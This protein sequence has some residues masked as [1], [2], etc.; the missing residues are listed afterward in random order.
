[1]RRLP[2]FVKLIFA[3]V[4]TLGMYTGITYGGRDGPPRIME[5]P[6]S[7]RNVYG[8][9]VEFSI[10][11][12]GRN[13]KYQ[14]QYKPRIKGGTWT[15]STDS[16][17][18][19]NKLKLVANDQNEYLYRCLV[20]DDTYS[21]DKA[22]MS[23]AASLYVLD[24]QIFEIKYVNET[25]TAP[26]IT[27]QPLS[28]MLSVGE[29]ATFTVEATGTD[30]TYQWQYK[31]SLPNSAWT[32]LTRNDG[33]GFD[34]NTFTTA[35]LTGTQDHYQYRCLVRSTNY[36][37][38]DEN[39]K[40]SDSATLQVTSKGYVDIQYINEEYE[41]VE[42]P[43]SQS[44]YAGTTVKFRV[45]TTGSTNLTY[46]WLYKAPGTNTSWTEVP[47]SMGNGAKTAELTISPVKEEYENYQ[48][49]CSVGGEYY[50]YE[51]AKLSS[52]ATLLLL[53]ETQIADVQYDNSKLMI[54][55]WTIPADNTVIKLPVQGTGLNITVDWGDGTATET[56]TTQ[57]PSH[58]Y[59]T[60]G[61]Y[62]IAV[63][64]ECPEWGYSSYSLP[65][66]TSNYYTYTQ[67]LT[68]VKQFGEL[69][70]T[71]YGFT[72]CEK[73]TEVSGDNLVTDKTFEK[74]TSMA[75]MFN[76]CSG[77]TTLDAS[78]FNTSNVTNMSWMFQYCKNLISLDL[79]NFDTSKVTDMSYMFSYCNSLTSLNI[80]N[81]N[82]SNV[83]GMTW[84]FY[85]CR[86][87]TSLDLSSFNTSKVT[88]MLYMFSNCSSTTSLD[89]S[90]FDTS[91]VTNMK[92]MFSNC[93]S[94]TSLDV[95]S[96]NTSNTQ[97]MIS[98]FSN[99]QS[100]TSLDVSN[101]DTSS[102]D[103]MESM[104][105]GCT[106]L[107]SILL[108]EKFTVYSGTTNMFSNCSKL[109]AVITTS[110]T[111]VANQ[112]KGLLPETA[113]LYVPN[114]AEDTYKAT[115]SG[116]TSLSQIKP[117]IEPVGKTNMTLKLG[118]EYTEQG[119]TVA[120][121]TEADSKYY[122]CYG[123]TL[124]Q[125]G[126][127]DTSK[128]GTYKVKYTLTK[129]GTETSSEVRNVDVVDKSK[130][131]ITEWNVSGDAG[132]TVTLPVS[133]TGL[134]I[135]VDWG[136]GSAIETITTEYPTHTYAQTGVYEISVLGNCPEWGYS[137]Y[138][139]PGDE[140]NTHM[141]YLTKI[142]QFGELNA[143][144]YGF[145][146]CG[147]L[148]EV[149]GENLATENTFK[150][151]TSMDNMFIGC[152]N[153][154]FTELKLNCFKT[155]TVTS[156]RNM[157]NN[158]VNLVTLDLNGFDTSNVTNMMAMFSCCKKLKNLDISTFNTSNVENMNSMFGSCEEMTSIDVSNLDT[159][160]AKNM[161]GMFQRCLKLESI[162]LSSFNTQNVE[163]LGWMFAGCT[164][165]E[166]LDLS[167]FNTSK[168]TNMMAMF[169][170]GGMKSINLSSFDTSKVTTMEEMF[171]YSKIE[172]IDVSNFNTSN[173][174]NMR[175][176][177]GSCQ[178]TALD[179]RNF[180]TSKVTDMHGMFSW[181]KI[182]TLDISNFDT[183]NVYRETNANVETSTGI[184][185]LTRGASRLKS[186][187]IGDKFIIPEGAN[188][189]VFHNKTSAIITTSPTP[190]ANQFKGLIPETTTLYVQNGS[191]DAYR[192]TL[193]G[194]TSSSKIKPIIEPIGESS[195][196][197]VQ[198]SEY[199]DEGCTVAGF[200]GVDSIYYTCYGYGVSSTSDVDT[201]TTGNYKVRYSLTKDGT[202][203]SNAERD[204][205]VLEM[206]NVPT[207]FKAS[208]ATS[209][210]KINLTWETN[211]MAETT[212]CKLEYLDDTGAWKK[213]SD[214]ATSPYI[215]SG[216]SSNKAYEYRI[217]AVTKDDVQSKFAYAIGRTAY[218]ELE[219]IIRNDKIAPII[220][221]IE[222]TP[223]AEYI[224]SNNTI[225][226]KF[227]AED[228]NY[229][230]EES[231]IKAE[232][233]VIKVGGIVNSD[234]TKKITKLKTTNGEEYELELSNVT[235][236]GKL[237]L[238]IPKDKIVDKAGNKNIETTLDIPTFVANG[239]ISDSK[240]TVTVDENE[241]TIINNQ[242]SIAEIVKIEYQYR[243][244][245]DTEFTT[246]PNGAS[247]D[248]ATSN[249][250]KDAL[251]DTYYEI[252]TVVEDS[253]GNKKESKTVTVKTSSLD[254][255]LI[256][257][258]INPTTLTSGD[259]TATIT[260]NSKFHKEYS[261]DGTNYISLTNGNTKELIIKANLTIYARLTDGKNY[262]D[263]VTYEV[264]NID[265]ERP[266]IGKVEVS[267]SGKSNSKQII[268]TDVKD[269]GVSGIKGYYI[270]KTADLDNP[271]WVSFEGTS[272]AYTIKENGTYYVWVSDNVGN[273]SEAEI[274][275]ATGIVSG[276]GN[277]TYNEEM[278]IS[279]GETAKIEITYTG[280]A[281]SE[282][283][284]S[285][286]SSIVKV[287]K[288][289]RQIEGVSVGVANVV[290]VIKDYDGTEHQVI[291]KVTVKP[292]ELQAKLMSDGV[293]Y[294]GEWT[295]KDVNAILTTNGTKP[296]EYKEKESKN[297]A[298]T[299]PENVSVDSIT[300]LTTITYSGDY[301]GEK[302]FVGMNKDGNIV[303]SEAGAFVVRLDK[304]APTIGAAKKTPG[305]NSIDV[306]IIGATDNLSGIK[307]YE[308]GIYKDNVCLGTYKGASG[309]ATFIQLSSSTTYQIKYKI[310]DNAGNETDM[311]DGG[312]ETT[313]IIRK[314][315]TYD[316]ATNGGTSV[317]LASEERI[318]GTMIDL[319][320]T[321]TKPGYNFKG[322]AKTP[323]GD[324]LTS[325]VM[326]EEDITLYAIFKDEDAPNVE[327]KSYE[328]VDG[329][330]NI[331]LKPSDDGSGIGGYAVTTDDGT[332][333]KWEMKEPDADGFVRITVPGTNKYYVW[334][335]DLEG[336]F[337]RYEQIA[338]KDIFAPT[339]KIE[340]K[341][342]IVNDLPYANRNE[343]NLKIT[344]EDNES[345]P[346]DIKIAIYNEEEY[347]NIKSYTSINFA[348]N[349]VDGGLETKHQ[350]T[351]GDGLKR[352]YVIFKDKAGNISMTIKQL[353]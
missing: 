315:V 9:N 220:E 292:T 294:N 18:T 332:P 29:K 72:Y 313:G 280:E 314:V 253:T 273:I 183:S 302:Y 42:Q 46:R 136:D 348:Y 26:V 37:Y 113:T 224:A 245:G 248:T 192:T 277:I 44:V 281:M 206:P 73:L 74:V 261:T 298:W 263:V 126:T 324:V 34:T 116:D 69:N 193:S 146:W 171:A 331:I 329:E 118:E 333:N 208:D 345:K 305:T 189:N 31:S 55:E 303:T 135:T 310:T 130:Y 172:K 232:D 227:K 229:K 7:Q 66:R 97:K 211:G 59:A 58:T 352:I 23:N 319:T 165:L 177:F 160:K 207:N 124:A 285:S 127:V 149:S 301:S 260:Y 312:S 15:N 198:G 60:A 28:Q 233:I 110:P 122:T 14:W 293:D 247:G 86:N 266:I 140:Y 144:K 225:K 228:I 159:S 243:I 101:F 234:A 153:E 197:V 25:P 307:E 214:N 129:D 223:E 212:K 338:I 347:K 78:N 141:Q 30:L 70:A 295:N 89:V 176:M 239:G 235:G 85:D 274:V 344:A 194:D 181:S 108:S 49:R 309:E 4:M 311:I 299:K 328:T 242:T 249:I 87:L 5:H 32:N 308:I 38:G 179:L 65:G 92:N 63:A 246:I 222:M 24:D 202:G 107:K 195:V 276:V 231:D 81:F 187:L 341:E 340:V 76:F 2:K 306:A 271:T 237:E 269:I 137:A 318:A 84:M 349:Y 54:T 337:V 290:V 45:D 132:L 158:C 316:Y 317:S 50:K 79:S 109:T 244:S 80:S 142:K 17:A 210:D 61:V 219:I 41:I 351:P 128:E 251:A 36:Y 105:S 3:T 19:T 209:A 268:A 284:S 120:G 241:I 88:S 250:L 1:M 188:N 258:S 10:T 300:G 199:I 100:L 152:G 91:K 155:S 204:V 335:K 259:V 52:V 95:S 166:T 35:V 203:F 170:N 279:V 325:L 230:Y 40:E 51:E 27:T 157:F 94:L 115:L 154:K 275:I 20:S 353:P 43:A 326:P 270:S 168:V 114:G 162:D 102:V 205:E 343:V 267:P 82:T 254:S 289:I 11:A 350:T 83:I 93:K 196:R 265:K 134:N 145:K 57:F 323:S 330:L 287:E 175:G 117:I 21:G 64:G 264:N 262:S 123:Y 22:I 167:N 98:M 150:N 327:D 216:L 236:V 75:Y 139:E 96:F 200:T 71:K 12:T 185:D 138:G 164:S 143:I 180:D 291:I 111:P 99:C 320:V 282:S 119:C 13:L 255:S 151:V 256:S 272:F 339:G 103:N 334:I 133:G 297:G 169:R 121:F 47:D 163:T 53:S 182:E 238:V 161:G 190:V 217:S 6:E 68:K 213:L 184:D 8:A 148:M 131:M 39:A 240:P 125:E 252:R 191:E 48:F 156:M 77:L 342:N 90:N 257:I 346:E 296:F 283:Y 186:I 173:V 16:G 67:Y 226:I 336:N 322:W 106:N 304:T 147:N 112:F 321:A 286:N 174:T 215:H 221:F 218:D 104:F 201:T 62:E 278:E 178:L 56:V 288:N 33:T